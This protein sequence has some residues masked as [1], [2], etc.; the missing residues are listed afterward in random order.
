MVPE[1]DRSPEADEASDTCVSPV[2][3][4]PAPGASENLH[5]PRP[6][7]A[8]GFA[9]VH[10]LPAPP[11]DEMAADMPDAGQPSDDRLQQDD[12]VR[13]FVSPSVA[14]TLA[15]QGRSADKM[16]ADDTAVTSAIAA[17]LET[18]KADLA[19]RAPPAA[20][21]PP[22]VISPV[23]LGET[24]AAQNPRPS[25]GMDNPDPQGA[26]AVDEP[27]ATN[28]FVNADGAAIP[29]PPIQT[30]TDQVSDADFIVTEGGT[31]VPRHPEDVSRHDVDAP[32]P[33]APD[34]PRTDAPDA[35]LGHAADRRLADDAQQPES[36]ERPVW[37]DV[38]A[39]GGAA[40]LQASPASAGIGTLSVDAADRAG[41]AFQAPAQAPPRDYTGLARRVLRY[42]AYG[43]AGWIAFILA[44]M[45]LY[46]F[47][48]PP[49]SSLMV[50]QALM[51]EA[52]AH[53]WADIEDISP[54]IVRAVIASEDARFCSHHGVDFD[55]LYKA[56]DKFGTRSV[57]GAS[58]ISMQVVKN[59]FLW[60]SKSLV[61]KA[62]EFPLT[63]ALEALWPKRRI[64]EV[65]LNIAEWGPG[66]FGV[67]SASEFHFHKTA[68][69]LTDREA[70][71]LAV[72]LP[73]PIERNA[74]RPGPGTLRLARF[75]Q[76]RMRSVGGAQVACVGP[77]GRR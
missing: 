5:P 55:A 64:M 31:A 21:R 22:L 73:N 37:Q 41:P 77:V 27:P 10:P 74:G 66:I 34:V 61:R 45:V 28:F 39:F 60:P 25:A 51:G 43:F 20:S 52:L 9:S 75:I 7:A 44:L 70:A 63:F 14:A 72:A 30:V 56:I 16:T 49:F 13:T 46:R 69:R 71:R 42:A 6:M 53:E 47:V 18:L 58:T 11:D 2:I 36:A 62:I 12:A 48:D 17:A 4:E 76:F 38:S 67:A 54:S 40:G 19:A 3:E 23:R 57:R 8:S 29:A 1:K 24:P 32:P 59:L 50:Q 65:Y 68:L 26:G 33:I 15:A 35:A